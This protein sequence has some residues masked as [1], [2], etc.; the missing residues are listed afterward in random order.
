MGSKPIFLFKVLTTVCILTLIACLAVDAMA[1]T[2]NVRIVQ[3]SGGLNVRSG[4]G[5][6]HTPVYLLDNCETVIVVQEQDGWALVSKNHSRS[7]ELGWVC[8]DYLK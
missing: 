3:A 5:T 4:P 8:L 6:E 2:L 7:V 1:E